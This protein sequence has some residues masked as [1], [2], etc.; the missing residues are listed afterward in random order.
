MMSL[1]FDLFTQVNDARPYGPLVFPSKTIPYNL[2]PSY[3]MDLDFW[4]CVYK[5]DLVF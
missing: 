5:I 4:V 1:T 3:K 2:D